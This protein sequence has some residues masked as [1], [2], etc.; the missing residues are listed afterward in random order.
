MHRLRREDVQCLCKI[1]KVYL[2]CLAVRKRRRKS[3][4]IFVSFSVYILI[5]FYTTVRH[6]IWGGSRRKGRREKKGKER[7]VRNP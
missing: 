5:L 7:G 6:E 1:H 3:Q 4:R 2:R